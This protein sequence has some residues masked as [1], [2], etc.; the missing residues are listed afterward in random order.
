MHGQ[1]VDLE[2]RH[3]DRSDI[4]SD[5]STNCKLRGV[6]WVTPDAANSDHSGH[7]NNV[8]G[9]S[10]VASIVNAVGKSPC[11]NPDGS[12]YWHSTAIIITW[13]DWGGWYDHEPP[14][15]EAYPQ[16]G[17]QMGFRVPLIVVSA[18]T[19]AGY[20]HNGREDFGSVARFIERNF[21]IMEGALTFADA[22]GRATSGA[23]S[24]SA[25]RRAGSSRSALRCR[26]NTSLI[27]HRPATRLMTIESARQPAGNFGF[28]RV[29]RLF[30]EEAG[31]NETRIFVASAEETAAQG[32]PL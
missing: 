7:V 17:Y 4:L 23:S 31:T 18:Y 30:R 25:I 19:P 26:R 3:Q 9:P 12:T 27:H 1:A 13:D 11:K 22:R 28:G 24:H 15:I 20:I 8:G 14:T 6:S 21:G 2:R 16:G 32:A 10:W 29:A 5:I